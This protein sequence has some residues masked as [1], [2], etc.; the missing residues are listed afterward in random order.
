MCG[1]PRGAIRSQ[2]P[3][4][5]F[6]MSPLRRFAVLALALPAWIVMILAGGEWCLMPASASARLVAEEGS[7]SAVSDEHA[8]HAASATRLGV[9]V[10]GV[11]LTDAGRATRAHRASAEHA[12]TQHAPPQH[13]P[14]QHAPAQHAPAQHAPAQHAP[15]QHAPAQHQTHHSG[16]TGTCTSPSACSVAVATAR[17]TLMSG[18]THADRP[19]LVRA[20]RPTSIALAPELPPPRA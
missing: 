6:A 5:S 12:P 2:M 7:T 3:I 14:P 4:S 11:Q 18:G 10:H 1:D 16:D 17:W 13:A 19:L 9:G 20:D 15:A 8:A